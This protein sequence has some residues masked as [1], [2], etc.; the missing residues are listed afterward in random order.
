MGVFCEFE[1]WLMFYLRSCCDA[2]SVVLHYAAKYR[3]SRLD[4]GTRLLHNYLDKWHHTLNPWRNEILDVDISFYWYRNI[5][6]SCHACLLEMFIGKVSLVKV[7]IVVL[8]IRAWSIFI[9]DWWKARTANPYVIIWAF[10]KLMTDKWH[11]A[12]C[13][14]IYTFKQIQRLIPDP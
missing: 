6:V 5:H 11:N 3:K 14:N 2:C 12:T 8:Q 13:R 4:G 9:T 7:L 1:V 10:T